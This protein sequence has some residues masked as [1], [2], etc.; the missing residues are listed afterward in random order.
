MATTKHEK[1]E[2]SHSYFAGYVPAHVSTCLPSSILYS[3]NAKSPIRKHLKPYVSH[4]EEVNNQQGIFTSAL[5]I[6]T[7]IL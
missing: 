7:F 6:V 1:E 3:F 2:S 4:M 5:H